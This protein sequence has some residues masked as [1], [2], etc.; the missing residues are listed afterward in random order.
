MALHVVF[1]A[2]GIPGWIGP[3]P[4]EGSEELPETLILDGEEIAVDIPF[5]A[6]HLRLPDGTWALRP[7]P[8]PPT[9]EEIA[10]R[11]AREAAALAEAEAR[12]NQWIEEEVARRAQPDALLRSMGRITIAELNA[13]VAAIRSEV[14]AGN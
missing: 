6:A 4:R 8:P 7:P 1:T 14:L 5:L 2:E 11:E 3:Q 12:R 9:P 13:R 10:A